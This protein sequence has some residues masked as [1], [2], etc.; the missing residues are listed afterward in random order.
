MPRTCPV[1]GAEAVR[2]KG[3]A[4]TRC[5]GIECSAKLL[6]NIVHFVSKDCMN[7]DGLGY[8]I[9]QQLIDN[10]LIYNIADIYSLTIEQI[11]SLKKNGQKFAQIYIKPLMIVKIII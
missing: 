8:S 7:I 4:V 5:I 1:C 11:A 2:E 10:K 6:R 3:E 9:V